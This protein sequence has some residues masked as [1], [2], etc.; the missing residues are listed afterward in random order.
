MQW[1]TCLPNGFADCKLLQQELGS[2]GQ[3]TGDG[4]PL[5]L[6]CGTGL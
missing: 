4:R 3:S 5:L 1:M 2:L 6:E